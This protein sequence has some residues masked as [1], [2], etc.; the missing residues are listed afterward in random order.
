[1]RAAL[2]L[3]V[4]ATLAG[5]LRAAPCETPEH[6]QFDFWLGDWNVHT[7]DGKL[8][9]ANRIE[10]GYGGCAVHER[11]RTPSGYRGESLNAYDPARRVWHQTWVDT[12]GLLLRLEGGWRGDRMVLEGETGAAPGPV[13]RHC[14][15]WTPQPDGSVRQVWETTDAAGA[16]RTAF[17]GLYRKTSP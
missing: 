10:K 9:G 13:T 12:G 4:A 2:A 14:I 8:V 16:W 3:I 5:P 15:S 17:D 7:P 6:R 11:Y 1:M